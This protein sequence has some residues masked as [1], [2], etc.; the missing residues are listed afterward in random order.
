MLCNSS[1]PIGCCP[2][3]KGPTTTKFADKKKIHN[4][5]KFGI[6]PRGAALDLD[7]L[8]SARLCS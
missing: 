8:S 4:P 6:G 5:E 1:P 2:K 7:L 3:T